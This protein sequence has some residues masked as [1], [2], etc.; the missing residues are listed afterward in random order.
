M[1]GSTVVEIG[2]GPG[3]LTRQILEQ[4]PRELIVIEK[5]R[6]FLPMLEVSRHREIFTLE[7]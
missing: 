2:P 5:D 1:P 7:K 4:G 3:T 6:R